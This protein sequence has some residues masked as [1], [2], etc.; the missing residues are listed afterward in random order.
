MK[1]KEFEFKKI[2]LSLMMQVLNY[3]YESESLNNTNFIELAPNDLFREWVNSIS[4]KYKV[5]NGY[6]DELYDEVNEFVKDNSDII[7][8][9]LLVQIQGFMGKPIT[10][11]KT[12]NVNCNGG[13]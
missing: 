1:T 9:K 7:N 4:K 5:S 11:P 6:T 10:L 12:F 13:R 2:R 3:I 8:L